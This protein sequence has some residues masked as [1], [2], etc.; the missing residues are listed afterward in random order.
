MKEKD[1][2]KYKL[3]Y[4]SYLDGRRKLWTAEIGDRYVKDGE[5]YTVVQVVRPLLKGDMPR[6]VLVKE[7]NNEDPTILPF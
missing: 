6:V 5:V 3:R 7:T 2:E 4:P 1:N